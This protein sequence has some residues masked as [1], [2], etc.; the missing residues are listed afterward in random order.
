MS[1]KSEWPFLFVW[2]LPR[3]YCLYMSQS[4]FYHD[5]AYIFT[6]NLAKYVQLKLPGLYFVCVSQFMVLL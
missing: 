4:R 3:K 6:A 1:Y 5:M 2:P